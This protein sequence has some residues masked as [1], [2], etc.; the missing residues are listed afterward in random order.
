MAI[1]Y[2]TSL[3]T[4]T[5]PTAT[6]LLTSPSHSGLHTD[7]NSAVEALETKVGVN[8]SAVT[9]SLDYKTTNSATR[10]R[11]GVPSTNYF[12]SP[13]AGNTDSTAAYATGVMVFMPWTFDQDT[14]VDRVAVEVTTAAATS[15]VRL[16]LYTSVN[17][18][19][20]ALLNDWGTVSAAATGVQTITIS[21]TIARGDYF[22]AVVAQVAG[23]SL[24]VRN[25][26][27]QIAPLGTTFTSTNVQNWLQTSVTGALPATAS[28]VISPA[29]I[30]KIGLR[31]T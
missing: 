19:P 23:C 18:T 2:P 7:I 15:V 17:C 26:A 21:Q 27:L 9:T 4:F 8:S 22:L 1:N 14:A 6:S 5:D 30:V 20:T 13:L 29:N 11:D 25:P 3:D 16:G 10:L 28:A 24:R 31:A 12:L